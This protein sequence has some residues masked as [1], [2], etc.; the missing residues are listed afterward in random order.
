[1]CEGNVTVEESSP[2]RFDELG[3]GEPIL[4][5]IGELGYEEPTPIQAQTIRKLLEG[6]DVIAQAQT[7]T[8]KTAAFS[9]PIIERLDRS[10]KTPQ[11]L[12][13]TPTRELAVQ[14]AEALHSYSKHSGVTVLPVYGGQPIE[15]QLRA[16]ERGV[17]I[18]VGTPGRLLDHIQRGTLKLGSVRVVVLDEADEMLD[19]GFIEDIEAILRE[20]PAER[21]TAFSRRRCPARSPRWP[22]ATCA[23]RSGSSSRP[24]R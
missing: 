7:G 8:G 16:L 4:K 6:V 17:H 1:M 21:Q 18:V 5:A 3:L 13:M 10:V 12:I 2:V 9:L 14:V 19:M 22:S 23:S 24:S 11:A 15:R 20:T